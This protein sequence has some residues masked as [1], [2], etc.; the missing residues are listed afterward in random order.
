M[1][2]PLEYVAASTQPLAQVRR[3][4]MNRSASMCALL[5]VA[6]MCCHDA[7]ASSFD[8]TWEEVAPGVWTGIRAD[9]TRTPV[10]G[11]TTL[12]VSAEGVVVFDGGGAP[13]QSDQV[14]AKV[15][16]LGKQ[17]VTH[18]IVSHW[19]GDHDYGIFRI[20]EAFPQA[21][22][23]SHPYTRATL[24]KNSV[25]DTF[26]TD[27]IPKIRERVAAR[28]YS[29]GLPMADAD[30]ARYQDILDNA[31][32]IDQQQKASKLSYPDITFEDKLTIWSG[33]REIRLLHLGLSNTA[34]DVILYLPREK[35]IATGDIDVAPTPYGFGS[36]PG[37]WAKS[38]RE[39]KLLDHVA[40]I[41]GHGEIQ[42]DDAYLDLLIETMELVTRQMD[43]LVAGGLD[44]E[45]AR[46]KMDFSSVQDRFTHGD[47]FLD[48]LFD[49]WFKT[50]ITEA[51][52]KVAREQDPELELEEN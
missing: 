49:I 26:L 24:D 13:L 48:R 11:N 47:A 33:D 29:T 41:P 14:V 52:W 38:L 16:E 15:R 8:M 5:L 34:G 44:L 2:E 25:D 9:S 30:V 28:T 6:L 19:H 42:R 21:Q 20:L 3:F 36:Y 7:S 35:I 23:I 4:L 43:N 50:P 31:A 1:V 10:L 27:Y 17:P 45:A 12:V 40:L 39:L 32:L 18:I 46:A 22:V 51:A 37:E